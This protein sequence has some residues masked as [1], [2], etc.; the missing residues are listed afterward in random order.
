[1]W[2]A[3]VTAYWNH[4]TEWSSP[5]TNL[6]YFPLS[7]ILSVSPSLLFF[8]FSPS[9]QCVYMGCQYIHQI[10][11]SCYKWRKLVA[12]VVP[13]KETA[14]SLS[15]SSLSLSLFLSLCLCLC[16]CLCLSVSLSL[17]LSLCLSVFFSLSLILISFHRCYNGQR[18]TASYPSHLSRFVRG[19]N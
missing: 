6:K 19:M 15:Q 18:A 9:L 12:V 5:H 8:S 10:F 4:S 3:I 1:L 11:I 2:L 13:D 16:L 7:Y 17:S 14:L